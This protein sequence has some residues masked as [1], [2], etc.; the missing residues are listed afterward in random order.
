[1]GIG[2]RDGRSGN[3]LQVNPGIILRLIIERT[4]KS[5][6]QINSFKKMF[7]SILT[8]YLN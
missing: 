5:F 1:M 6:L 3:E 8:D 2:V 4:F 7:I